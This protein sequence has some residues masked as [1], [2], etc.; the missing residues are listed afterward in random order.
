M[1]ELPEVESV[2]RGLDRILRPGTRVDCIELRCGNFRVPVQSKDLKGIVGQKFVAIRRRAKYLI[3][4]FQNSLLLNHLGMTG[5]WRSTQSMD[6]TIEKTT[7]ERIQKPTE[8]RKHD[9]LLIHF[10]DE[11]KIIYNDPR[12]FG[13]ILPLSREEEMT[14]PRLKILGPEP[15]SAEFSGDFIFQ[16]TRS[17][18]AP[19]KAWVMNQNHVVGVGNIYACEALFHAR[20][21][22]QKQAG[23]ITRKEAD[24]LA[25]AIRSVLTSAIEKGGTTFRD[26]R[27]AD[28]GYGSYQNGLM[29]YNQK[30]KA[31]RICHELIQH[32]VLAG[33]S[34]YWCGKC[35]K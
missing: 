16:K 9:H 35:Q 25:K 27:Q 5:S 24:L 31:C 14:H 26:F 20:V 1:P 30:R 22:P 6:E 28:G 11:T 18:K 17:C 19:I 32:Q 10:S 3:F 13:L 2:C 21:R 15:L 12:R 33:R 29:V 8:I 7:Q 34:T 23:K 4:E